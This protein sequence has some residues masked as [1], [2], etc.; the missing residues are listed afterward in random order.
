MQAC[1]VPTSGSSYA[2]S[3]AATDASCAEAGRMPRSRSAED[4][5]QEQL[6][7]TE[8]DTVLIFIE[9]VRNKLDKTSHPRAADFDAELAA[10]GR[11][12]RE[13][14]RARQEATSK[15]SLRRLHSEP[16]GPR[17]SEYAPPSTR[18]GD[19]ANNG[20]RQVPATSCEVAATYGRGAP[21]PTA[22]VLDRPPSNRDERR[23]RA[24]LAATARSISNASTGSDTA[25][26]STTNPTTAVPPYHHQSSSVSSATTPVPIP[27]PPLCVAGV[28]PSCDGGSDFASSYPP[29]SAHRLSSPAIIPPT[30]VAGR[31]VS[32]EYFCTAQQ[33]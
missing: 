12:R 29:L 23:Q 5:S 28:S 11:R 2:P 16:N 3:V 18:N 15:G 32:Q 21:R 20:V 13:T 30:V 26:P 4:L 14:A 7:T 31:P 27:D 17:S 19:D 25:T 6:K 33:V 24:S 8:S 22:L 1:I 10:E 9:Y